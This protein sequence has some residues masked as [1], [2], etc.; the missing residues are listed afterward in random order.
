MGSFLIQMADISLSDVAE[1]AWFWFVLF[2]LLAKITWNLLIP[3]QLYYY[4][5]KAPAEKSASLSPMPYIDVVLLL[6]LFLLAPTIK[7]MVD[8][9]RW[10]VLVY[11]AVSLLASYAFILVPTAGSWIY[12][13][14]RR[15]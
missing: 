11:G 8:V 12:R 14:S 2:L 1:S 7:T 9:S 3:I 6:G 4:N 13:K 15:R 10:Q 5:R